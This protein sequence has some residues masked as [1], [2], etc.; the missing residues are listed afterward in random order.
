[1]SKTLNTEKQKT[2]ELKPGHLNSVQLNVVTFIDV[3]KAILKKSLDGNIYM[4]DNSFKCKNQETNSLNTTCRQGQVIN[5]IIYPMDLEKRI[6]GS[7]P[8]MARIKNIVF[9]NGQGEVAELKVCS[10]LK[11]YG[12]VHKVR[13]PLAPN[14]YYW[15]GTVL[16]DLPIGEYKYRLIFEIDPLAC[17]PRTKNRYM[18]MNTTAS[19]NVIQMNYKYT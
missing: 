18:N 11:I 6:D 8:P 17:G 5:W 3:R 10:E 15:A 12:G 19:L 7:F 9:L 14:Y 1:M 13:S 2:E 4:M 16:P